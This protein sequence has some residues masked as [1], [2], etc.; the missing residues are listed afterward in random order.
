MVL[1]LDAHTVMPVSSCVYSRLSYHT[2]G[3]S[4]SAVLMLHLVLTELTAFQRLRLLLI[5][6]ISFFFSNAVSSFWW[7]GVFRMGWNIELVEF[8]RLLWYAICTPLAAPELLHPSFLYM[9]WS[10]LRYVVSEY[11]CNLFYLI[12]LYYFCNVYQICAVLIV[13]IFLLWNSRHL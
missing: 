11:D 10:W 12:H 3:G 1:L 9:A 2:I 4:A 13:G 6:D 8:Q 7:L 5:F